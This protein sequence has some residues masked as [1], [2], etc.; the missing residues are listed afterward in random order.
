MYDSIK[1]RFLIK[2]VIIVS[3]TFLMS[4]C[5]YAK[6]QQRKLFDFKRDDISWLK[7]Y[8][9]V[10]K[11]V[12]KVIEEGKRDTQEDAQSLFREFPES[13]LLPYK[14]YVEEVKLFSH[15]RLNIVSIRMTV[16]YYTGGAHGQRNYYSWNWSKTE[17][18]F[19]SLDE[20]ISSDKFE[21]LVKHTRRIL[22]E[23]QKQDDE[24]DKQRKTNI[25]EGVSQPE[26]FK[27]WNFDRDGITFTFPE[28]QTASYIAGSFEVYIPLDSLK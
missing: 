2:S 4:L 28:Y 25:Q 5:Y 21:K 16:Y 19:T 23:K 22:F 10:Q 27:I 1:M 9:E 20:V 8:P 17:K 6:T 14:F 24:Y 11:E 7:Q 18:K 3:M 15:G 12:Q 26:D 13:N